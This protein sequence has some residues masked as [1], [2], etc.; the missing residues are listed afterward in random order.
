[1]IG[2]LTAPGAIPGGSRRVQNPIFHQRL[3]S[4]RK[5]AVNPRR[6]AEG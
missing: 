2:L 3:G 1:M 5:P 4:V 6:D